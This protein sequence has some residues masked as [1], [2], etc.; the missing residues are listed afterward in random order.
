MTIKKLKREN[1]EREREVTNESR[2]D[3]KLSLAIDWLHMLLLL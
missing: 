3:G 1:Y 2:K